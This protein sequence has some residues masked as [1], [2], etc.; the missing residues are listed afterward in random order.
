MF[1]L[2]NAGATWDQYVLACLH[3][4]AIAAVAYGTT[5]LMKQGRKPVKP[6]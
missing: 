4:S 5:Q 6:E 3:Y 1:C 2:L